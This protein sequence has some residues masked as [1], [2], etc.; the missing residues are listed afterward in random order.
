MT[1]GSIADPG[2]HNEGRQKRKA[3]DAL[4]TTGSKRL[5]ATAA[6]ISMEAL[7]NWR[8]TDDEFAHDWDVAVQAYITDLKRVPIENRPHYWHMDE[9]DNIIDAKQKCLELTSIGLSRAGVAARLRVSTSRIQRWT[10][11]DI[12]FKVAM[13]E[14]REAGADFLE[15]EARRRAVE[16]VEKPVFHQGEIV[17]YV[18]EYS[19]GL[20]KALLG[21]RRSTWRSNSVIPVSS[22]GDEVLEIR[23]KEP[24]SP[25]NVSQPASTGNQSSSGTNDGESDNA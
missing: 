7:D 25:S 10:D 9:P 16:G 2:H 21:S 4:R 3:V 11:G 13:E 22:N 12:D 17:G 23:W 19:D 14:A 20:L 5:A 8:K 6:Q 18:V 1:V 24:G 15:D